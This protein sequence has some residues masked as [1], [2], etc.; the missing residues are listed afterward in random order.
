MASRRALPVDSSASASL[1]LGAAAF[2]R[3]TP[4]MSSRSRPR[5]LLF[6]ASVW[7]LFALV[8]EGGVRVRERV[9][10]GTFSRAGTQLYEHT[11]DGRVELKP[12][13]DT[14]GTELKVHV[15]L[16]GFR[17]PEVVVPKPAGTTRVVCIGGSTTFDILAKSDE[18]AWP[19]RLQAKLRAKHPRL[20]VVNAGV[21]GYTIDSYFAEPLWKKIESV[22]PDVIVGYF[23]TNEV[24][25]EARRRF[26]A[27]KLSCE[28]CGFEVEKDAA[29]DPKT[30][31]R[32][33]G[34]LL[35][36]SGGPSAAGR[37][38]KAIT[39][40]SLFAFKVHLLVDSRKKPPEREG[41]HDLP[42]EAARTFERKLD[43]LARRIRAL[44]AKPALASFALRWSADQPREKRR[45]LAAGA[46]SIY[47]GLSLD[48][49]DRAF[50][51]YNDAIARVARAEGA[52]L[53]PVNEELS[54]TPEL[55]GDFVHF[56]AEGSERMADV[57]ARGLEGAGVLGL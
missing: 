1:H 10:Y 42:D 46:F 25:K 24:S 37:A 33:G 55:F 12:G 36:T 43:E 49:I 23:A 11:Q 3:Y 15:G 4:S 50:R 52:V 39:D 9:K 35:D 48:G 19:A 31:S 41:T 21:A 44:K 17:G 14:S 7:L 34:E 20:E 27:P 6:A 47:P 2:P 26:D 28:S 16:L 56:S 30:C 45:E 38:L 53:L 40:W 18:A 32:C 13:T 51:A 54:G 8:C 5:K 29:R 22:A 57:V